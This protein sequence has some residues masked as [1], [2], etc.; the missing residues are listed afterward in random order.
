M[1]EPPLDPLAIRGTS[2]DAMRAAPKNA[3]Y[4]IHNMRARGYFTALARAI[5]RT[6]LVFMS[7]GAIGV[8][9]LDGQRIT[10]VWDHHAE[11]VAMQSQRDYIARLQS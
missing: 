11:A 8:G 7:L 10:Y 9:R 6:D 4:I 3:T 5:G 2:A 1:N